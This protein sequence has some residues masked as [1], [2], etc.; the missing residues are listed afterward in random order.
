MREGEGRCA[1]R[2][3]GQHERVDDSQRPREPCCELSGEEAAGEQT[4]LQAADVGEGEAPE[5]QVLEEEQREDAREEATDSAADE[6]DAVVQQLAP[7]L[8]HL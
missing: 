4:E 7:T 5:Q 2:E 8:H 1:L 3:R 6:D